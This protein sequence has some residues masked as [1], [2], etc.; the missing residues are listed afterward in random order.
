MDIKDIVECIHKEMMWSYDDILKLPLYVIIDV[1]KELLN[2][3]HLESQNN[4]A[5]LHTGEVILSKKDT[6][7]LLK[8]INTTKKLISNIDTSKNEKV[9]YNITINTHCCEK[10]TEEFLKQL[11]NVT[12]KINGINI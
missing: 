6:E 9:T 8:S 10:S 4:L 1:H 3:E 2:G 12:K 5:K 7:N 11:N